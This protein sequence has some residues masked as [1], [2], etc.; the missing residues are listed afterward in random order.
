[1]TLVCYPVKFTRQLSRFVCLFQVVHIYTPEH[2]IKIEPKSGWF[3]SEIEVEIDGRK[4]SV[5]SEGQKIT[6]RK[7][8]S[9][10]R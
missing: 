2:K 7:D 9:D 4:I 1:M 5:P 6:I 3:E 10:P 8:P